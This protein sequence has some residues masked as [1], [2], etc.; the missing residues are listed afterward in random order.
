VDFF[1]IW[2]EESRKKLEQVKITTDE[3]R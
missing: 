3:R 2:A 1:G